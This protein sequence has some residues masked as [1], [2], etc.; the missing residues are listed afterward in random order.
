M[1][2]D[3]L[4][5]RALVLAL[6]ASWAVSCAP[7]QLVPLTSAPSHVTVFIDGE[8]REMETPTEIELRRDRDHTLF[9]K[10]PGYHPQLVILNSSPEGAWRCKRRLEPEEVSLHLQPLTRGR[11]LEI[12]VEDGEKPGS[13]RPA[14]PEW[15]E[16]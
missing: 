3:P 5:V 2:A 14:P 9:F 10:S 13:D 16:D 8:A 6:F 15:R 1:R 4:V 11:E 12:E 7:K